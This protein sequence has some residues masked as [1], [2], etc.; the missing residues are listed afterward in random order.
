MLFIEAMM[1]QT[2]YERSD[3]ASPLV[4]ESHTIMMSEVGKAE[5]GINRGIAD[6]Y[7][8]AIGNPLGSPYCQAGLYWCYLEAARSLGMSASVIPMP[9]NGMAN[10]TFDFFRKSGYKTAYKASVH[11]FIIW[12]SPKNYTGH[13]ER[14]I[15]V[16][17]AGWVTTVGFNTSP[18]TRG[19]QS[20]GDGV[21]IRKRNIRHPLASK[22]IRGL[23]GV[24]GGIR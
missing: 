2:R 15:A 18:G 22:R 4:T 8:R 24:T 6:K 9:R 10:S 19:S 20:N 16:G 21:Y 1:G 11:D 13:I 12:R 17:K 7:N 23:A 14:I 3:I 5:S